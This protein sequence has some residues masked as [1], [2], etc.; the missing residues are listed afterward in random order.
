MDKYYYIT[1][2]LPHLFFDRETSITIEYFLQESK[3]WLGSKEY[4]ILSQIK[5]N[6]ISFDKKSPKVWQQFKEYETEFRNDLTQWRKSL[7]T[8]QEYK[9]TSFSLSLVKEGNPLEIERRLL[10]RKWDFIESIEQGHHFDLE[11]LMLYH[12]KLQILQRLFL[13]N[14]EKGMETFKN[15]SRVTV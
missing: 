13:F 4:E 7:G 11:L 3:K 8:G 15:I 5:I 6:D 14:K 2:Q 10:K 12:L 9:P 1:S